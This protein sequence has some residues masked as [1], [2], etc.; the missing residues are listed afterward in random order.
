MIG[1]TSCCAWFHGSSPIPQPPMKKFL[2]L[3]L[4]L[5]PA[6][7]L[8]AT[9]QDALPALL[10]ARVR[11]VAFVNS[12]LRPET[13]VGVLAA[14]YSDT[15]TIRLDRE[16]YL[17]A[18][19]LNVIRHLGVSN[20]RSHRRGVVRGALTGGVAGGIVG[21]LSAK[22]R[23]RFN[24]GGYSAARRRELNAAIT[25]AAVGLTAGGAIGWL[26]PAERWR[27]IPLPSHVK[28]APVCPVF[29]PSFQVR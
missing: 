8:P 4:L 24:F 18:L 2:C 16:G 19:P 7:A 12:C 22:G 13:Y 3:M 23:Q 29:W 10:G 20:G 1:D 6:F 17:T 5:V 27:N 28:F 25:G 21:I 26:F 14:V 9:A 15:I 11:A